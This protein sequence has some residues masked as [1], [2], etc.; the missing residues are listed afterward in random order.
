MTSPPVTETG[1]GIW[2]RAGFDS[3]LHLDLY[4]RDLYKTIQPAEHEVVKGKTADWTAAARIDRAAF[5]TIWRLGELGLR[6]AKDATPRSAFLSL[7]SEP[8]QLSGFA[9]VGAGSAVAYLQ[10]VAVHPDFRGRG[11]GRSLVRASLQWGRDHGGRTMLLNTQPDNGPAG[12]LYR[13]EGFEQMPSQLEV[14]RFVG[15]N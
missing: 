11:Y 13:S 8:G 1:T 9:V 4:T 12:R 5:E 14:L 3:F 10:R 7:A 2:K 15:G 6:E